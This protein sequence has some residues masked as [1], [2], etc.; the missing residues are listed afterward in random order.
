MNMGFFLSER[1][2]KMKFRVLVVDD[3]ADAREGM[4]TVLKDGPDFVVIA[5]NEAPAVR[6]MAFRNVKE[7]SKPEGLSN[8]SNPLTNRE[9]EILRFLARGLSNKEL[10]SVLKISE[11]TVKNHLRNILQKLDLDNRVQLVRYAFERGW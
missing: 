3:N 10:A 8:K 11:N 6:E 1:G 4:W 7:F 9:R 2:E 5:V